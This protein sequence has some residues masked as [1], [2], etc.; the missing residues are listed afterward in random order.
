MRATL[1]LLR[2][3]VA[4]VA[5]AVAGCALNP[6][7]T[8]SEL[9]KDALPHT[10]VPTAWKA[11]A[12]GAGVPVA[13]G[14]LATFSDPVL[15]AL[16]AEALVYNADLQAAAA[17]VEQASGY[18]AVASGSLWPSVGLA[19]TQSGKSGGG[20]GLNAVFLNASL[21][22]DV[23]GR[24]RYGEAAAE[25]RSA[26]AQADYA[27]ARQ[28]LAATVARAWFVAIEAGMQRAIVVESLRSSESLSKLAQ[29]RWR[30]G[31]GNE[32]AA[33]EARA[34]VG[35]YRDTLRQVDLAREQ[36]LRALELLLGRYPSAEIA[37]AQELTSMPAAVP[38]GVPSAL[39]E[40]RPDVIA[41]ERRVAAAFDRVG[42]AKAAQLPRISLTAGGSSL[43]SD[44]FILQDRN[45][46]AFSFGANLLAPIYQGGAL[47]AQVDIRTAEQKE[48]VANYARIA[49]RSFGEVE[50]ALAAENALRDRQAILGATIRDSE[51]ALELVQIQ[52]RVGSVDLRAVEQSQLALYTARM[53]LL[54][55]ET[56]RLAQRVNLY[57]ALGG[58]FDLPAIEPVAAH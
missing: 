30:I 1:L 12:G 5:V 22:L 20:G 57:L 10:T 27:Y 21:E 51:R 46:P 23:W 25:A 45:N 49:Q 31:N 16:V 33:A 50:N 36:A 18:V 29:E 14:W 17:R 56:E 7:P 39:L 58:G 41:A 28:S 55:V 47:R 38:V 54:R 35:T 24:L 48:A 37:V 52:Y 19:A 34:N 4:A 3:V 42:E 13:D 44:V 2:V 32:Q 53:S 43:S 6:P 11:G 40:R 26:A 9:Q 15:S 8:S